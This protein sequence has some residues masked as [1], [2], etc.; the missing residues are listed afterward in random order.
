MS[1]SRP[2]TIRYVLLAML[3]VR[4]ST[5][6]ELAERMRATVSHFWSAPHSQIYPQLAALAADGLV[7]FEVESAGEMRPRK[8]YRPTAA[9]SKQLRVWLTEPPA[10][11]PVRD[12]LMVRAYATAFAD[13]DRAAR[14]YAQLAQE[15]DDAVLEFEEIERQLIA[16]EPT[17][18]ADPADVW[19]GSWATL[20]AGLESRRAH[21]RWCRWMAERLDEA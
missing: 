3:S 20:R 4:P 6:Q 15:A 12:E 8:R 19:F 5:G 16:D 13:R 2:P 14:M 17:A 1:T 9:G 7:E 21:A 18:H 10:A 11:A